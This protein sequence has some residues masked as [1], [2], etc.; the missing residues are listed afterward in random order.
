MNDSR[1]RAKKKIDDWYKQHKVPKTT[2]GKL[3]LAS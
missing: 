2:K 1:A 3:L